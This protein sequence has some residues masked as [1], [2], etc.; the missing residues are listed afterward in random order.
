[1]SLSSYGDSIVRSAYVTASVDVKDTGPMNRLPR[2]KYLDLIDSYGADPRRWPADAACPIAEPTGDVVVAEAL[3]ESKALDEVL[4]RAGSVSVARQSA[5]ADRI[6]AVVHADAARR[7]IASELIEASNVVALPGLSRSRLPIGS[8]NGRHRHVLFD[9]RA[10]A[11]LAA[12]LVLGIG[13]GMSGAARPTVQAVAE[14][15]GVNWDRSVLALND[16]IG[17]TLAALDDEDV[18]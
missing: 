3:E 5:L 7:N 17:G 10:I 12:T 2:Q 13:V 6:M 8:N 16:E 14:S 11:A 18:L 15:V 9:W 1:M 4:T